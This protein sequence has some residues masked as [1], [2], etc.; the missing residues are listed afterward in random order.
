MEDT[1]WVETFRRRLQIKY[2]ILGVKDKLG[3]IQNFA[4]P[5]Q[6]PLTAICFIGDSDRDA[7]ALAA[8]GLGIAPSNATADAKAA[9]HIILKSEGGNGAVYE[10]YRYLQAHL[11]TPQTTLLSSERRASDEPD[12]QSSIQHI[13]DIV[14]RSIAVQHSLASELAPD[15][16]EAAEEITTAI[17]KGRRLL[18][19]GNGGS[20]ADAHPVAYRLADRILTKKGGYGAVREICDLILSKKKIK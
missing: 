7:P 15:I 9:A 19:F 20:A 10:A 1:P 6:V 3:A 17:R 12:H 11:G 4:G 8:V 16:A 18:V 13:Q 5:L 2:A 14:K